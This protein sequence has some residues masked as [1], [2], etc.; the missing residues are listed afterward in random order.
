MIELN[1]GFLERSI[2]ESLQQPDNE[3]STLK[4]EEKKTNT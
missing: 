1:R 2:S 4:K 3:V